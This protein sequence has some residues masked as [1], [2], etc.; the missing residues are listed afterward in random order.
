MGIG[1]NPDPAVGLP[2]RPLHP[3]ERRRGRPTR[4]A[5]AS[6]SSA[7][8]EIAFHQFMSAG[9]AATSMDSVAAE[10]RVSK[11][12]LD[13]RFPS[14]M[15]LF[16]AALRQ[17]AVLDCRELGRFETH[18]GPVADLLLEMG[19]WL[20]AHALD[21]RQVS[22][23]RLLMAEGHRMPE[24]SRYSDEQVIEPV[25]ATLSRV[26]ARAVERGEL[27]DLPP[28]FLAQ[29]FLQAVCGHEVRER[30]LGARR[31]EGDA[32]LKSRMR[33]AIKLFGAGA[34]R[35]KASGPGLRG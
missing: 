4:D 10:A 8:L 14:K 1:E 32:V 19:E 30:V 35:Q 25:I 26:F 23:Y 7:I 13:D 18:P 33:D 31:T 9:Y 28:V 16:E 5:A 3:E 22:L 11:R 34:L 15:R 29:Q 12:T 21:R 2:A 27:V 17:Q 24:L 20:L 6:L